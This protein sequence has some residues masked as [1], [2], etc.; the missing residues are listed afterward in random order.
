MR[1]RRCCRPTTAAACPAAW[2][3]L[4]GSAGTPAAAPRG[5]RARWLPRGP[6]RDRR[7]DNAD[8]P[9]DMAPN[10]QRSADV[11]CISCLLLCASLTGGRCRPHGHGHRVAVLHTAWPPPPQGQV[12]PVEELSS[13]AMVVQVTVQATA[14]ASC[15]HDKVAARRP[16][17][18]RGS[19]HTNRW[20]DG[21]AVS[22]ACGPA[23]PL[24]VVCELRQCRTALGRLRSSSRRR[25]WRPSTQLRFFPPRATSL[26]DEQRSLLQKNHKSINRRSALPR[27]RRRR[28][29]LCRPSLTIADR[30][31]SCTPQ[32]S[33]AARAIQAAAAARRPGPSP[34]PRRSSASHALR[35]SRMMSLQAPRMATGSGLCAARRSAVA[36]PFSC[37]LLRRPAT[38]L[39]RSGKPAMRAAGG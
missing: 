35:C 15:S 10:V 34:P 28:R 13:Q 8:Q 3:G 2:R 17:S 39:Q 38:P 26:W 4:P 18:T 12:L 11:L 31:H 32:H 29:R 36:T 22:H 19:H 6:S 24:V 5:L 16:Q 27:R 21:A 20:L 9:S 14:T 37:G 33:P 7:V 1:F 30:C 23:W 25:S